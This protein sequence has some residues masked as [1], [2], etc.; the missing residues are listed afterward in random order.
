MFT[1]AGRRHVGCV[2][3]TGPLHGCWMHEFHRTIGYLYIC[4]ARISRCLLY[5]SICRCRSRVWSHNVGCSDRICMCKCKLAP[6]LPWIRLLV[7][8]RRNSIYVISKFLKWPKCKDHLLDDV[9]IWIRQD[10]IVWINL[11]KR[12]NSLQ[13]VEK[14]EFAATTSVGSVFQMCVA[15]NRKRK[16]SAADCWQ[17]DWWYHEAVGLMGRTECSST[18]QVV[19]T[20]QRTYS[21]VVHRH[22]EPCTPQPPACTEFVPEPATSVDWWDH[23]LCGRRCRYQCQCCRYALP[24]CICY[25]SLFCYL[26]IR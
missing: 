6:K 18:R 8:D 23:Q 19:D 9:S 3:H 5:R 12:F 22:V 1:F 13:K 11:K 20:G 2:V 15:A 4:I 21:N 26:P 24:M 10:M 25:I 16:D 14:S 7:D 17:F